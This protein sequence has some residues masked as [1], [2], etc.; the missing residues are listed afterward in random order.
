MT[1]RRA[2]KKVEADERQRAEFEVFFA[3]ELALDEDDVAEIE[4]GRLFG[5]NVSGVSPRE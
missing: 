1:R 5:F 2:S 4:C 3:L